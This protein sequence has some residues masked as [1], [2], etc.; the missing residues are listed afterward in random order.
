MLIDSQC[1][2]IVDKQLAA[3]RRPSSSDA[4]LVRLSESIS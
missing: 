1:A 4:L 3:S 2:E